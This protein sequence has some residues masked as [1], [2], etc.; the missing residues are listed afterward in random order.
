MEDAGIRHLEPHLD[1]ETREGNYWAQTLSGGE[2][3]RIGF[4]RIF[5]HKPDVLMLDEV[6]SSMDPGA[7]QELYSRVIEKLPAIILIS[8]AHRE[9]VLQF[10]TIHGHIAD[11][12]FRSIPLMGLR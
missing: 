11:K 5:L 3:Q 7:E 9:K 12:Q 8:I 1:D 2:Q 4:A 6:T 10:H